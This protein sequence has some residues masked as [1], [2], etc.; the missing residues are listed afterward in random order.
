MTNVETH[1]PQLPPANLRPTT[2]PSERTLDE[3]VF[4]YRKRGRGRRGTAWKP[5]PGES[6]STLRLWLTPQTATIGPELVGGTDLG[7]QQQQQQQPSP[8]TSEPVDA[9]A[10]FDAPV[11][12]AATATPTDDAATPDVQFIGLG[13]G[14]VRGRGRGRA[15]RGHWETVFDYLK[16]RHGRNPN[17]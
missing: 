15:R 17:E 14:H 10:A 2:T 7:M 3:S 13:R 12:D 1:S 8:T 11:S 4:A 9:D 6:S 5:N 16:K